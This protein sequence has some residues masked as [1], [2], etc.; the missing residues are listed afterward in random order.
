MVSDLKTMKRLPCWWTKPALWNELFSYQNTFFRSN[1]FGQLLSTRMKTLYTL[2]S[3]HW[4]WSEAEETEA[5]KNE[6]QKLQKY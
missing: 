6:P 1:K 2:W 4:N 3:L 5:P